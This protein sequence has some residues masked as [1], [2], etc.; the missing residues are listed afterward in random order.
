MS[1]L[2]DVVHALPAVTEAA[3]HGVRFDWVVEEGFAA[4]VQRHP[5][6]NLTIPIAWRRWRKNLLDSR[7]EM[8]DF[9]S[10]LRDQH[11]DLVLDAQGLLKSAVVSRLAR[12][13]RRIGFNHDSAR[14]GAASAFYSKRI[15]V[16][17]EQHAI[18]RLRQLF[19]AA[20]AYELD[21]S[22]VG[23]GIDVGSPDTAEKRCVMLHGTTWPSKHWP[24][25]MWAAL[26]G[27]L[28]S[29]G[30]KVQLPW[31]S[32]AEL[33]RA[34]QVSTAGGERAEVLGAQSLADL[35]RV[36]TEASLAVGVDSGLAH[37]SAAL[38]VPTVVIY[39]ST[40]SRLTGCRGAQVV[41][42]QADFS[43]SPCL[44]KRCGYTGPAKTW[45]AGSVVPACYSTV[46][47]ALVMQSIEKLLVGSSQ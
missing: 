2:G 38:G 44:Q 23:S 15:S 17:R 41:N 25:E 4:V 30:F 12:G 1:S 33:S 32:D 28:A 31:G 34:R 43:C 42:L 6:V 13:S 8:V 24:Q 16:A 27:L 18:D 45:Q 7:H 21:H 47:P 10:R 22:P 40:D 11:Y 14:E 37:L 46:P 35:M 20:F 3:R 19:A 5:A 29:A 26:A 9:F 36:L 39:G